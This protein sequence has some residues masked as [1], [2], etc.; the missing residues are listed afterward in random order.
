MGRLGSSKRETIAK[1]H[2][3]ALKGDEYVHYVNFSASFM[4]MYIFTNLSIV[5]LMYVQ[6]NVCNLYCKKLYF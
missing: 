1:E 4:D 3:R 6:F 5:H 2:K